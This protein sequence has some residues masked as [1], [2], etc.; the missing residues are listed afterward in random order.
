MASCLMGAKPLFEHMLA[1]CV[2]DAE[3]QTFVK[4]STQE[5]AFENVICKMAA[6]SPG[7]S[8]L[9]EPRSQCHHA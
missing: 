9:M 8:V 5:N 4:I 6:I 3:E 2:L 7:F 1:Y